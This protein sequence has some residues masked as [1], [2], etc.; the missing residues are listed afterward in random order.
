MH[1]QRSHVHYECTLALRK[2]KKKQ[3]N[4]EDKH[5]MRTTAVYLFIHIRLF[6]TLRGSAMRYRSELLSEALSSNFSSRAKHVIYQNHPTANASLT[7]SEN[8]NSRL[9]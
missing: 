1:S 2:E 7:L 3:H 8:L 6:V 9:L 5:L 4:L